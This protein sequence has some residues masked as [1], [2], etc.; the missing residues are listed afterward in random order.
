MCNRL[1]HFN[2]DE[3]DD[4]EDEDYDGDGDSYTRVYVHGSALKIATRNPRGVKNDA[5][6]N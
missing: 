5:T 4:D 3:D 1:Y 2:K 6:Q